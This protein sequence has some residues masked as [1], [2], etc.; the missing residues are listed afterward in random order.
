MADVAGFLYFLRNIAQVP[1]AA[2]P[3]TSAYVLFAY[4]AAVDT[5]LLQIQIAAPKVYD[6][7]V[8][9]W[10]TDALINWCPD[11][12]PSTFFADARRLYGVNNFI[13]G[14][15]TAAADQA[16]SG[17]LTVPESLKNLTVGD[18]ASLK[19]PFGRAYLEIAQKYGSNWGIS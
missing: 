18:L 5:V 3:D 10:A 13:G 6:W 14:I 19:T 17:S 11:I 8:Y 12:P 16:T 2:L 7:A 15:A 1:T 4:S 9:N